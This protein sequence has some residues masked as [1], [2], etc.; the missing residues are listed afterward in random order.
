MGVGLCIALPADEADK[1]IS[2]LKE[3]GENACVLGEVKDGEG[4]ELC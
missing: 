2:V 1:A 4:V 3:A